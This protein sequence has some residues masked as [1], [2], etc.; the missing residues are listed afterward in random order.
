MK[1][2]KQFLNEAIISL[3]N[4]MKLFGLKQGYSKADLKKAYSNMARKHHP[5]LGGSA[6]MMSTINVANEVLASN[7][8]MLTGREAMRAS[9]DASREKTE[10]ANEFIRKDI[11]AKFN[12]SVYTTYFKE[13]FGKDFTY[14]VTETGDKYDTYVGLRVHFEADEGKIAF[15]LSI[16]SRGAEIINSGGSLSNNVDISYGLS[17]TSFGFSNRKKAKMSARDYTTTNNHKIFTTPSQ[18]FPKAKLV[19]MSKAIDDPTKA[20]KRAD[21]ELALKNEV[22]AKYVGNDMYRIAISKDEYV[23]LHRQVFMKIASWSIFSFRI[24]GKHGVSTT[25]EYKFP[26]ISML[27]N[28]VTIDLLLDIKKAKRMSVV[29]N[30]LNKFK[31]TR[32][33]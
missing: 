17:V 4:A 27:E 31:K 7:T 9:M 15:D 11:N 1:S 25:Q 26:I 19:K 14:K 12:P 18:V 28:A 30:I 20:M 21:F 6:K 8:D 2:Y 5:D 29:V 16:T 10:R 3:P 22:K 23:N 32:G 13:I 33:Y 24:E